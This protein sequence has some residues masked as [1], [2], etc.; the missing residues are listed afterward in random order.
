[1][2]VV[3]G[4][5]DAVD[6]E[7]RFIAMSYVRDW[8]LDHAVVNCDYCIPQPTS[9]IRRRVLEKV[10]W[11]DEA[12]SRRRTMSFGCGSGWWARSSACLMCSRVNASVLDTWPSGAA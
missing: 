6:I 8:D 12:S 5:C 2:D 10:G 3:Y 1:M 9:F 4:D 7:G 11:L